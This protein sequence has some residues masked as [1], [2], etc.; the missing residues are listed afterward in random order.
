MINKY[1]YIRRHSLI[2]HKRLVSMKIW[3]TIIQ[4]RKE[5]LIVSDD[6][7]ADMEANEKLSPIVTELFLREIKLNLFLYHNILYH[8]L[9]SKTK[10]TNRKYN[11]I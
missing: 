6:M 4:Q 7:T 3:K 2:I 5:V 10:M 1:I 8:N 9:T 11:T